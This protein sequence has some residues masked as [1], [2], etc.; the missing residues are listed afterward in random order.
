MTGLA[1]GLRVGLP[2]TAHWVAKSLNFCKVA[3]NLE[4]FQCKFVVNW[5]E[6]AR[7]DLRRPWE[8]QDGIALFTVRSE[9]GE[10]KNAFFLRIF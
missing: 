3:M 4:K 5:R 9:Q 7:S 6:M 8:D 2:A 1:D 10:L